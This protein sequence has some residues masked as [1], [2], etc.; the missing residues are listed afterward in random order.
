M[1]TKVGRLSL[2][3]KLSRLTDLGCITLQQ[4]I[5]LFFFFLKIHLSLFVMLFHV[6]E[7]KF[8]DNFVLT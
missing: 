4:A 7:I 3:R 1:P 8:G 5:G 2:K 6:R